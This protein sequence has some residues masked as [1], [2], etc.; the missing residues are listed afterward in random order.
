MP[1]PSPTSCRCYCRSCRRHRQRPAA[2][3]AAVCAVTITNVLPPPLPLV[4]LRCYCRLCRR[5]CRLCRR[6]CRHHRKRPAA[7][8]AAI[9]DFLPPVWSCCATIFDV[10][11][12]VRSRCATISDV[13]PP[14]WSR[15]AT[16]ADVLLLLQLLVP[17]HCTA[18]AHV[19]P[20]L[21]PLVLP[22]TPPPLVLVL[23][24]LDCTAMAMVIVCGRVQ[25]LLGLRP[26]FITHRC[27]SSSNDAA[28]VQLPPYTDVAVAGMAAS[29]GAT[30][31][32]RCA[33]DVT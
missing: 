24:N 19:L 2:H 30:V 26:L 20:L 1:L 8:A 16:I 6:S 32:G 11:P 27:G 18:I 10:L 14:V 29:G 22:L 25:G 31:A 33:K 17:P 21:L 13:L 9:S 15:C 12:P 5:Y 3:C 7:C 28:T 4:P 23:P